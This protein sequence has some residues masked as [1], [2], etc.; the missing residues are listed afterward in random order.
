M[1]IIVPIFV[2]AVAAVGVESRREAIRAGESGDGVRVDSCA[3][4]LLLPALLLSFG[5]AIAASAPLAFMIW[6]S[7]SGI[8]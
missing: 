8:S 2:C 7:A 6:N 5:C 4:I 3:M 1:A